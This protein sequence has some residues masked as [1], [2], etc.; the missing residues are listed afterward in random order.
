MKQGEVGIA[1]IVCEDLQTAKAFLSAAL[2]S[3]RS[4]MV[5]E[6]DDVRVIP[7]PHLSIFQIKHVA[8]A[9]AEDAIVFTGGGL[10]QT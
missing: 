7:F 2:H 3:G 9:A 5:A 1:N 8:I 4:L 10:F 6:G